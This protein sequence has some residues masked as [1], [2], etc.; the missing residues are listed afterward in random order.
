MFYGEWE[1]VVLLGSLCE[2][3]TRSA[4][5]SRFDPK[6]PHFC[7]FPQKCPFLGICQKWPFSHFCQKPTFPK[8]GYF[9][10]FGDFPIFP[11][12]SIF[13]L[14]PIFSIFLIFPKNAFE[15]FECFFSFFYFL[16]FSTFSTFS[17]MVVFLKLIIF[18]LF[19]HVT[20]FQP[21][22]FSG[23][24]EMPHLELLSSIAAGNADILCF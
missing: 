14:F 21:C 9:G 16:H 22:C 5:I 20:T 15:Q 17:N 12:F 10:Y 4:S 2:D 6:K 13:P 3:L 23:S 1:Y 8:N 24:V 11:I 18:C 19:S 7:H